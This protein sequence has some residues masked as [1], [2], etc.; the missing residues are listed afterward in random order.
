MAVLPELLRSCIVLAVMR[1]G[2]PTLVPGSPPAWLQAPT[3]LVS[4]L[5]I[6]Q[7]NGKPGGG[8]HPAPQAGHLIILP[9]LKLKAILGP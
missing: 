6:L 7:R 1:P 3:I 5:P 4:I 2:V 8:A 9:L